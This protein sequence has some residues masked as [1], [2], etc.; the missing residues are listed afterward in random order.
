MAT[1]LVVDD[2][3]EIRTVLKKI[4]SEEGHNILEAKDGVECLNLFHSA[5][6]DL[7]LLDLNL[8]Q[9]TGE[10]IA[11][12]LK[13]D[14]SSRST[15]IIILTGENSSKTHIRLL[16]IGVEEFLLK[17]FSKTHLLARVRSLLRNKF[18]NDQLL[19][20]FSAIESLE[21]LHTLLI[22]RLSDNPVSSDD[23][24]GI[25][26][27]HCLADKP[28]LGSPSYLF[29]ARDQENII[30][31]QAIHLDIMGKITSRF[32]GVEKKKMLNLLKP[33][34]QVNT[35]YFCD[36]APEELLRLF[37]KD[38]ISGE[39]PIVV[40]KEAMH[41][42][43]ASGYKRS[44]GFNDTRWL[45]SIAKQYSLYISHLRQVM[46]T[47]KAFH[48][49]LESL[50]RAAEVFDENVGEH[51]LRV[52]QLSKVIAE[53]LHLSSG[54]VKEI[55]T[56]AMMHDVGKIQIPKEILNKKGALTKE[57]MTVI[58]KHPEIGAKILGD[59]P[60]LSFAR[61]IALCHHEHYD[62]SGYPRGLKGEDIPLSARIVMLA[63]VYDSLRAQR[64]YKKALSH[65]EAVYILQNGDEKS[66]PSYFD[67]DVLN[68]FLKLDRIPDEIYN[69]IKKKKLVFG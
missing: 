58:M 56:S 68:S 67:P 17:P 45:S 19:S 27:N 50:A 43:V 14:E 21:S 8:P 64:P 35:I 11:S 38:M 54:F 36:S 20:A 18:L 60:R 52:N 23:F 57:E 65:N 44:V 33:Y 1:I 5:K 12:S 30:T 4:L 28:E 48:Y 3:S 51:I 62:G 41:W 13:G 63:D 32:V 16:D 53:S 29:L 59:N 15:P 61:D 22:Q 47:E 26:L 42:V 24:I 6:P 69:S 2:E 40:V 25:A 66:K 31:G 39:K 9:I 37:F 10:Q 46:E 34:E 7:I 55:S 49:A